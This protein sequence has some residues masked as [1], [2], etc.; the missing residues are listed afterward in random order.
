MTGY[1]Q[2]ESSPPDR[3]PS[4]YHSSPH[5]RPTS[6]Y[7]HSHP[8]DDEDNRLFY[9]RNPSSGPSQRPPVKPK[10]GE[11][12]MDW[13]PPDTFTIKQAPKPR[14]LVKSGRTR[15]VSAKPALGTTTQGT[16]P[17]TSSISA[18]VQL[19]RSGMIKSAGPSGG[20]R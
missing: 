12:P 10:P 3:A 11:K 18:Y 16:M 6:P 20:Y 1:D 13:V 15:P 5:R 14:G 2:E 19:K 9:R 8:S 4:S 17:S 7:Q